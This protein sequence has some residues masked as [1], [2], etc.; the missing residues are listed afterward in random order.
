G[1]SRER[2]WSECCCGC[3]RRFGRTGHQSSHG[4]RRRRSD[5]C[6]PRGRNVPR[7]P[8]DTASLSTRRPVP[9]KSCRDGGRCRR[10]RRCGRPCCRP[11][12]RPGTPVRRCDRPFHSHHSR[13][14][15]PRGASEALWRT[16]SAR[17]LAR[18][19]CTMTR[20]GTALHQRARQSRG[21]ASV[22]PATSR[23]L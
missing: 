5:R 3:D 18:G 10:H 6:A 7:A 20:G 21:R 12:R 8:A 16:T 11:C 9:R 23:S 2:R 1:A 13:R 22:R 17:L 4:A 14:R 19:C 15:L